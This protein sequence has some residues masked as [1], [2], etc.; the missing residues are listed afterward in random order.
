M[1]E[2]LSK[3]MQERGYDVISFADGA[4]LLSYV[5]A[6][7]PACIFLETHASDRSGLDLLKKLR[8]ENCPAPVFVT[9]ATGAISMAVDAV[10]NGAFDFIVKPFCS[11]EVA[12]PGRGGDRRIFRAVGQ[13]WR[14][15]HVALCTRRPVPDPPRARSAGAN[16]R[17]RDQQGNRAVHGP[18]RANHRGLSG[19]HH[20]Q[21]RRP[22]CGR[23]APPRVRPGFA[24][25]E[26]ARQSV[27]PDAAVPPRRGLTET[28]IEPVSLSLRL[29]TRGDGIFAS[30]SC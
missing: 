18:E 6:R 5:K 14:P 19:Q 20:A 10:R 22:E 29:N 30:P 24:T 26:S 4:S 9:S 21:G 23:T 11:R 15:R 13:R 2:N 17:W 25:S 27:P 16:S 12:A 8:A 3:T 1:R 7:T 28:P